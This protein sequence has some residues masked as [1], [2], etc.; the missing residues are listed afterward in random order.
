MLI[1]FKKHKQFN[2][3]NDFGKIKSGIRLS[4][5][6][7]TF[8]FEIEDIT[9]NRQGNIL[10]IDIGVTTTLSCSNGYVSKKDIHGHDLNSILNKMSKQE[11]NSK[12]FHRSQSHRTNYINWIINQLDLFN[13]KQINIEKIKDLRHK[14]RTSRKLSSW[15]YTSIFEKLERL[16]EEHGVRVVKLN[17]AYTSQRCSKCGWV[18]KDNRNGK[19]FSCTKCSFSTDADMNASINLSLS[20]IEIKLRHTGFYWYESEQEHTVPVDLKEMDNI[21]P[22]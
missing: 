8:M 19:I 12:A 20:L 10:G 7:I 15:T 17:P 2:K 21:C 9:P 4:K 18:Y 16:A 1:P 14:K 11:K 3:W 5:K 13:I 22:F 6:D